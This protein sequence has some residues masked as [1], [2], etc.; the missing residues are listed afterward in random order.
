M[1]TK[2][3]V[4]ALNLMRSKIE[5]CELCE[6]YKTRNKTV[7]GSGNLSAPI[8]LIGEGPGADEDACGEAFVGK[9]G[10][11]LDKILEASGFTREQHV[12]IGNI[13]KCR[14]PA[15][16]N[17]LPEEM[18]ACLPYLHKQIEL[19]DPKIIV[20]MGAVALKGLLGDNH[21]ITKERGNWQLWQ[22]RFLMPVYHPAALLRNPNLKRDTWEDFK[23]IIT[24]YREIGDA[25]HY[26]KNL[27]I[28]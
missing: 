2:D 18:T 22:E 26:C 9:A 28:V 5:N 25:K 27:P 7:F 15:N 20:C 19:I 23:K 4:A 14:P 13:V 24:K 1:E 12:F 6:L 11:L 8:M 3:H 21:R 10:K 16:R 17:P